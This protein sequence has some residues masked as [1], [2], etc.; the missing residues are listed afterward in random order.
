[1]VESFEFEC[2]PIGPDV[3]KFHGHASTHNQATQAVEGDAVAN[4]SWLNRRAIQSYGRL[5]LEAA[6]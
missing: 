3:Q 6:I 2:V 1:M 4:G 5:R